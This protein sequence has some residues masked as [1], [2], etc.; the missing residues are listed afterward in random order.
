MINVTVKPMS[1]YFANQSTIIGGTPTLTG[2]LLAITLSLGAAQ[3]KGKADDVRLQVA[4]QW[5][6]KGEYDKAVQEYR[7]YLSEHPDS[8]EIYGKVGAIRLK[9]GNF[10]LASE[11]FKIALGKN[12]DLADV[13]ENLATAYEKAGEKDKAVD[14]WRRLGKSTQDPAMRRRASE[15]I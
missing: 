11:N 6:D 3:A 14:E 12:P 13:R 10:K 9:Q 1:A 15:R 2:L 7:L 4:G 8:P 5:A